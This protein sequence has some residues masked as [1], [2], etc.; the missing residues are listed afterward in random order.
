MRP[1]DPRYA[2]IAGD[3]VGGDAGLAFVIALWAIVDPLA[4]YEWARG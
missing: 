3:G 1:G 4:R 2:G